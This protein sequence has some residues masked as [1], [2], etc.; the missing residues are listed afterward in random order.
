MCV[1]KYALAAWTLPSGTHANNLL[2]FPFNGN[3]L[4]GTAFP[5]TGIPEMPKPMIPPTIAAQLQRLAP[6]QRNLIFAQ[7][8]RPRP[9]Q[10]QPQPPQQQFKPQQQPQQPH[11]NL[12]PPNFGDSGRFDPAN[13]QGTSMNLLGNPPP[14]SGGALLSMMGSQ[15]GGMGGLHRRTPSGNA[16]SQAGVSYEMLQSFMQRNPD[17][18]GGAGIGP[19]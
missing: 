11:Y 18:S 12:G 1:L 8:M 7:M 4:V 15:P 13:F 10:Q 3:S 6:D 19:N 17:G 16:M 5:T 9:Q 14:A 2:I